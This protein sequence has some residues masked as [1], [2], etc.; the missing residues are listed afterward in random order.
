[1]I[2]EA[3]SIERDLV[4]DLD[5]MSGHSGA[6]DLGGDVPVVHFDQVKKHI[7]FHGDR[8]ARSMFNVPGVFNESASDP[9]GWVE[10]IF[11]ES[12]FIKHST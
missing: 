6:L 5:E 2:T 1:M 8:I 4:C 10:G 12:Q 9:L 7:R 3:C 11:F